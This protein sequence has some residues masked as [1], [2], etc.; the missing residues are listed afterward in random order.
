MFIAAI[1]DWYLPSASVVLNMNSTCVLPRVS[2]VLSAAYDSCPAPNV[3]CIKQYG[4]YSQSVTAHGHCEISR[5][6]QT[7]T[8][9]TDII[10]AEKCA[11]L[12]LLT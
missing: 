8:E 12:L 10:S 6:R 9:C 5:L 2:R 7:Q 4:K 3:T 1:L 11:I